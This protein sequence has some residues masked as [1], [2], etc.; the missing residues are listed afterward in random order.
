MSRAPRQQPIDNKRAAFLLLASAVLFTAMSAVV[1][2]L[3]Q[4]LRPF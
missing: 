3:G 1:K 2:I 4:E